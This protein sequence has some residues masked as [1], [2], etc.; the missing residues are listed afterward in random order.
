MRS[1]CTDIK[2]EKIE[3]LNFQSQ[4]RR[5]K[6]EKDI[7]SIQI[8]H[9]DDACILQPFPWKRCV[10]RLSNDV[11]KGRIKHVIIWAV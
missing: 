4:Q 3:V 5:S 11:I 6:N 7:E 2:K 8:F 10:Q 1:N 9:R